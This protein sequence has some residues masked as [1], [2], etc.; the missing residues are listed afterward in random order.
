MVTHPVTMG[1][2]SSPFN[3]A[4]DACPNGGVWVLL[5]R[6][7]RLFGA[8]WRAPECGKLFEC[9]VLRAVPTHCMAPDI[10]G[11]VCRCRRL[12][13]VRWRVLAWALRSLWSFVGVTPALLVGV[14]LPAGRRRPFG[15]VRF[16]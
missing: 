6:A 7:P 12:R 13:R 9:A 4:R 5:W 1:S 15:G 8:I 2:Q 16:L 11:G 3:V 14:V 10:L